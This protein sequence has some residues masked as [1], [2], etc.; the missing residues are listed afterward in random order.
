LTGQMRLLP[1]QW[2]FVVLIPDWRQ[3]AACLLLALTAGSA[4]AAELTRYDISASV[5]PQQKQLA[6]DLVVDLPAGQAGRAVEF[7]LT[8]SLKIID[9]TPRVE[10]LKDTDA[11]GF[12][13]INGSSVDLARRAGINRYRVILP[14][15]S[16]RLELTYRGRIDFPLETQAEEYA[17]GFRETPGV[18]GDEG[19]YLAGSTLWYPYFSNDLVG[20]KLNVRVPDGWH[21]ISQ[22]DGTSRGGDGIAK[23][24]S[25]GPVDEIYLVGGPLTRYDAP[26]GSALAEV[27]L[28]EPDDALAN[29]YLDATARYIEMYRS[30]IGPYPYGKFA[31]VE[32]FWETG[33][34]MPSF[35]LLG[36]QIIRFP[37]ILTSS[38]P[39]EILHN[40]WGNS[41]FVDY[42]SGNWC[43]GL[44][45]YMADHLIKEQ[46]GQGAQYRRDTLK[47]YRDFVKEDRDFPLT[48]FRSRHSAATEAIGYGKTL[49]GF[50]VLR[51]RSGDDLFRQA[52]ANFYRQQR[53]N[54]ASF[55]DV[56][57]AFESATGAD[58]ERFF[59]EWV[60]L[61]GAA[62]LAL[63]DVQV[64]AGGKGFLISGRLLQQQAQGPFELEVPVAIT[65]TNGTAVDLIRTNAART[66]FRFST[67]NPPLQLSLDPEFD[68]FRLLDAR[69][70]AP[71]IGQVFGEPAVLVVL[72]G[73]ARQ[74]ERDAW[75]EMIGAW[76]SPVQ[77]VEFVLDDE[78]DRLPADRAIWLLGRDNRIAARVFQGGQVASVEIRSDGVGLPNGNVGYDGNSTVIVARHPGNVEKAVGWITVDPA[79][80]FEGMARKLPHYGKY[81]YLAFTGDEPENFLKGEWTATDS[82]LLIDLRN[83]GQTNT[84]IPATEL[85]ARK[86][87][88]ELPPIFSRDRLL[89]HVNWLAAPEREGR[90][91]GS[92]GLEASAE[93]IAAQFAEIGLEPAGDEGSYFQTF[94]ANTGPDGG[95]HDIRNVIGYLP[96]S[97]PD[98]ADQAALITAHYDHLG[99]GWPDERAQA[100][101]GAIYYGADDNASGVAVLI[102]LARAYAEESAPPRSL[103]FVAF[104]GEEAGL[105]GSAYYVEHPSPAPLEGIIGVINMDTVGRLGDQPVTVLATESATEWPHVFRG[106]GFT[107]GIPTK[108]V[109]G[110]AA[111]S[112]QHSFI[113]AGVPGVQVFTSAHLDY[114]R[115]SD[116]ADKVDG[117]GM[118]RVATVV[119]EAATYLAE[120]PEPLTVTGEGA[121]TGTAEQTQASAGGNRRRVSFGTV[122][123][124]AFQGP[125]VRVQSVVPGSPAAQAG[126]PGGDVITAIDGEPIADLGAFSEVLKQFEPGDRVTASA[127]REGATMEVEMEL[128]AR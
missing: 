76:E 5:K 126:I 116:T 27:Y 123:D 113:K 66:E 75:R 21:L 9:S 63:E 48:E 32:N 99:R 118:V 107:T 112:D 91:M 87:L 109:P 49:M 108:S 16:S 39:H 57:N 62:K 31:L 51:R 110:A 29:K 38:Y 70:T 80:A 12:Q 41:V 93:Y 117:D 37:F 78:V 73:E 111:S 2:Y 50:H 28:R 22:G 95:P 102:E 30:L 59:H 23:W 125:G 68:V 85:P 8:S 101:P 69:E 74:A 17:R 52:L 128:S 46:Q 121:D 127:L 64:T 18:I 43:E 4:G 120:R 61:P 96:G 89:E 106:V 26:A 58:L 6:V 77:S 25:A 40:W 81:S 42:T 103:V 19:V 36:S 34:G 45:A 14:E 72:P 100:E 13:G 54:K 84:P 65:T 10:K 90:G 55:S 92:G 104:S 60:S 56:R 98:F 71:S 115:P 86:P 35:T 53:G 20:F 47:K 33:Y 83:A 88:A 7:L 3:L 82:P 114:H 94:T 97:N 1:K 79:A 24:D 105:L 15:D 44:T 11:E 122:P 119:K 67:R 124:F